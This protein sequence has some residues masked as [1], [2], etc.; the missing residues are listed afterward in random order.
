MN[1]NDQKFIVNKPYV[2]IQHPSLQKSE[3]GSGL[4]NSGFS[5]LGDTA[6]FSTN[7][8]NSA[9]LGVH[10]DKS[11]NKIL[12]G[13]NVMLEKM[14]SLAKEASDNSLSEAD[15]A[16][17]QEQFAKV[18]SQ[19]QKVLG[20]TESLSSSNG[21]NS[22]E[23]KFNNVISDGLKTAHGEIVDN[24]ASTMRTAILKNENGKIDSKELQ[25]VLKAGLGS[26]STENI[27]KFAQESVDKLSKI[28]GGKENAIA[29]INSALNDY[30]V[31]LNKDGKQVQTTTDNSVNEKSK[32]SFDLKSSDNS[33][34]TLTI[35]DNLKKL[36][37]SSKIDTNSNNIAQDN[38][39]TAESNFNKTQLS[40]SQMQTQRMLNLLV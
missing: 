16:A 22:V 25:S 10:V 4:V 40:A 9:K 19:V 15:R 23:S 20:A 12:D 31:N 17:K 27:Q 30:G 29:T 35:V 18:Y 7:S 24:T 1:V 11:S 3:T 2:P 37:S 36:I 32:I 21:F 14:K 28:L 38:T 13:V 34:A 5:A 26:A 6:N 8:L 39:K 33:K